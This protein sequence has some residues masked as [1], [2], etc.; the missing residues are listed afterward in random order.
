MSSTTATSVWFVHN[1][2]CSGCN[3]LDRPDGLWQDIRRHFTGGHDPGDAKRTNS[4]SAIACEKKTLEQLPCWLREKIT[5]FPT[6]VFLKAHDVDQSQKTRTRWDEFVLTGKST[7]QGQ[8][9]IVHQFWDALV[10]C[11]ETGKLKVQSMD[12]FRSAFA[13][14]EQVAGKYVTRK[15]AKKRQRSQRLLTRLVSAVCDQA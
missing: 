13:S 14:F 9:T 12:A 5:V 11:K 10:I 2:H 1:T 4:V 3:Y 7:N 6:I 15:L 8:K